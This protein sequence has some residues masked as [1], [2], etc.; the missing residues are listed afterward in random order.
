MANPWRLS[1]AYSQS[2]AR[3]Y[4]AL[5]MLR[6]QERVTPTRGTMRKMQVG[7]VKSSVV[8]YWADLSARESVP[9]LVPPE[10]A[11]LS[12]QASASCQ[13]TVSAKGSLIKSIGPLT[14]IAWRGGPVSDQTNLS[15]SPVR[16]LAP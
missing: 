15:W 14:A 8:V 1:R 6:L 5:R 10:P 3:I 4:K 9:P 11:R 12:A 7:K 2:W 16:N 13:G